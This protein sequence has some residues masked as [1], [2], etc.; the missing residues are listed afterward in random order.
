MNL[1]ALLT[2]LVAT[3][4][5]VQASSCSALYGQCGGI[6]WTGPT[7]CDASVCTYGNDWYSQCLPG[8]PNPPTTT[9]AA[10]PSPPPL[11]TSA[12][13]TTNASPS[14]PVTNWKPG[15]PS[16]LWAPN[17][18]WVGGD[19]AN[20]PMPGDGSQCASACQ[21]TSG[22]THFTW[23]D[24]NTGTCWLKNGVADPAQAIVKAGNNVLCG[25]MTSGPTPTTTGGPRPTN[26]PPTTDGIN[27]FV[28][29]NCPYTI[30][31]G[32]IGDDN[33]A[34]APYFGNAQSARPAGFELNSGASKLVPLK[35]NLASMRL[36]ARTGC[37]WTNGKF[38]C[39]VGDCG[40]PNNNYDGTCY[41][42]SGLG[43]NT[44]FEMTI[45]ADSHSTYDLSIV[46][47]Y[48]VP[49][50]VSLSGT[51]I[52]VPGAGPFS[53]GNPRCNAQLSSC[54]PEVLKYD[55]NGNAVACQ[56]ISKAINDAPTRARTPALA[57][58]FSDIA[59][60]S[61]TECSCLVGSCAGETTQQVLGNLRNGAT[62]GVDRTGFCCSP[63]NKL[64][65]SDPNIASHICYATDKPK[66]LN[67][68]GGGLRYDEI[69][70]NLCP[71]A[72]S[73]E[74]DDNKSTYQ[75]K[76]TSITYTVS[77]C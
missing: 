42:G 16:C 60:R 44:L 36:W 4:L 38:S 40:N 55:N 24:W 75:C 23:T 19:F 14:G 58:Y 39:Q 48:S 8:G 34:H 41:K 31:P 20:K 65:L 46:D 64:Y 73:W 7:C 62:L 53:C 10:S 29:N 66:P 35:T 52:P 68:F 13:I 77:F 27:L 3:S 54:P 51:L 45:D 50:S 22:C 47:G 26:T 2:I 6:G 37:T 43:A 63:Y 72:Y 61:H 57:G 67:G 30:W 33:D 56:S 17:C 74:F 11:P 70:K 49:L 32:M 1:V 28:V 18:D 12:A 59:M 21:Q 69:F 9:S 76:G 5:H 71:D 15:Q 25:Y